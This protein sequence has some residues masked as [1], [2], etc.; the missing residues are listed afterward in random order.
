M[1]QRKYHNHN[2]IT[3]NTGVPGRKLVLNCQNMTLLPLYDWFDALSGHEEDVH[4]GRAI[5]KSGPFMSGRAT[6]ETRASV[7]GPGDL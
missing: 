5:G 4:L 6:R 7:T 2:Y 3:A 1:W